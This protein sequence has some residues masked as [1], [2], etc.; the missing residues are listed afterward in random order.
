MVSADLR[1]GV[2][3]IFLKGELVFFNI[4][5][6]RIIPGE[7]FVVVTKAGDVK[8]DT[9]RTMHPAVT[10]LGQHGAMASPPME[11]V[12]GQRD[13]IPMEWECVILGKVIECNNVVRLPS[14]S[15]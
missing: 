10:T 8:V 14:A 13:P 6:T 11:T 3:V 7:R 1:D 9:S 15:A 5:E 2:G 12:P 4:R